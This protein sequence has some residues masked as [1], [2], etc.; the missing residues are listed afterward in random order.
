VFFSKYET[1]TPNIE[2]FARTLKQE[3]VVTPPFPL[4]GNQNTTALVLG[5]GATLQDAYLHLE[6]AKKNLH[7]IVG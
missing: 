2:Q 1:K 7:S 3:T 6:E 4:E 5:R